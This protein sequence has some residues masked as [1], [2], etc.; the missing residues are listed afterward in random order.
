MVLADVAKQAGLVLTEYPHLQLYVTYL[1]ASKRVRIDHLSQQVDRLAAALRNDLSK[2]SPEGQHLTRLLDELALMERLVAMELSPE[3]YQRF[4][5]LPTSGLLCGWVQFLEP[6]LQAVGL[7]VPPWS[8]CGELERILPQLTAFY[9]SA[10]ERDDALV[11]HTLD[12][13]RA[14]GERLAVLITGGFHA[15]EITRRLR[16]HGLG[17]VAVTPQVGDASDP[18]LYQ[19]VLKYSRG[20]LSLDEVMVVAHHAA[21]RGA[22][23]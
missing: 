2:A 19:A 15:P 11:Q 7:S 23:Q 17:V 9:A 18:A 12:K 16:E 4:Q 21:H 5:A 10:S 22:G 14:S 8:S 20:L 1:R 3:E 6:Q 13:L